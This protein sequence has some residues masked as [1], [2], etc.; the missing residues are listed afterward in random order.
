MQTFIA[1][2][3]RFSIFFFFVLL[4][5]IALPTYLQYSSF[6]K[7][8]FLTS[9]SSISG[10]MYGWKA[11]LAGYFS[12]EESNK[13]LKAE[14]AMLRKKISGDLY[15]VNRN[16]YKMVD[17]SFEQQYEYIP[18]RIINSTVT[19]RNNY[20]TLDCGSLQGVVQG[21]GVFSPNG[22]IGIVHNTSGHYS[23]VKSLLTQNI[24]ID[25]EIEGAGL[26]G[27]LKWNGKSPLK[28]TITGV[29]NDAKIK[30]GARVVT[31]ETLGLFPRGLLVG[32]VESFSVLEGKPLWDI[33]I[34]FNENYSLVK[35]VYV[36]KNLLLPER[37]ML[38]QKVPN[39]L[40]KP[41]L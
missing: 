2:F 31:R 21:M 5:I 41:S 38:E 13:L 35:D 19:K 23:V 6:P 33:T 7:S 11:K 3:K 34:K 8:Q 40:D 29:S 25:V 27:F 15:Q 30:K 16:T 20:F 1:F 28:G 9:A 10:N 32:Y 36:I 4:Q 22:I 12:L 17:T 14:N 26:F 24:N 18:A 37:K 39:T